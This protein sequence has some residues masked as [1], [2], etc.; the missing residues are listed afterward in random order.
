MRGTPSTGAMLSTRWDVNAAP[1]KRKR[2]AVSDTIT[3]T[4]GVASS[5]TDP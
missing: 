1:E 3:G 4:N 2:Q 5:V